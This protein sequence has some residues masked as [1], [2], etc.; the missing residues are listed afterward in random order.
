MGQIFWTHTDGGKGQFNY[1]E[2]GGNSA[3][4][5]ISNAYYEDSRTASDAIV[6]LSTQLGVDLAANVLKEFWPDLNRK[7]RRHDKQ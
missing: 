4:V 3:A 6:K 7:F 5:A 1:S 2:I